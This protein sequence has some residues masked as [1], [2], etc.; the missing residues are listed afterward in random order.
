MHRL[1]M[2]YSERLFPLEA[3]VRCSWG[4]VRLRLEVVAANTDFLTVCPAMHAALLNTALPINERSAYQRT[5]RTVLVGCRCW[6]A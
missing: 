6:R 1:A 2:A 5:Y 4:S 3:V